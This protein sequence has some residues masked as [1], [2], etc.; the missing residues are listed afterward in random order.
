M[1]QIQTHV[2]SQSNN[3]DTVMQKSL[4]ILLIIFFGLNHNQAQSLSGNVNSATFNGVENNRLDYAN[5]EIFKNDKLVASLITDRNGYYNVAL[6]TG[7]YVVNIM[8]NGYKTIT[9]NIT[10]RGDEKF[11]ANLEDDPLAKK[12]KEIPVK[13]KP[14]SFGADRRSRSEADRMSKRR[15]KVEAKSIDYVDSPPADEIMLDD[16]EEYSEYEVAEYAPEGLYGEP[17]PRDKLRQK[18]YL[19]GITASEI[20]DFSKWKLWE[21]LMEGELN[22]FQEA[23]KYSPQERYTVQLMSDSKIPLVDAV[24]KLLDKEKNVLWQTKTDNTGKAELWNT[25]NFGQEVSGVDEITINYRG[26]T[27]TIHRPKK[28]EKGINTVEIEATC[29]AYN[30]VDI[31]FVVDATGSMQDEIDFL[32]LEINDVVYQ[33]KQMNNQLTM[34]FGSVFYRD[35]G[36][37]YLTQKQDFTKVLSES[38]SFIKSQIADGGGDMPEAVDEGLQVA[39]EEM[40]WSEEARTRILF[41][42]LDA[43]PHNNSEVQQRIKKLAT[44]AA[45]KGIRIVPITASGL[46]KTAEYLMRSLALTTNGTY[47]FITD[48]SGIGNSHLKPSTDHYEVKTLN[49]LLTTLIKNYI[50]V[51]GCQ[52]LIPEI[53]IDYPDSL[54]AQEIPLD[55]LANDSLD[56]EIPPLETISWNFYPNPTYGTL[57]IEVSS[58]VEMLYLTDMTGK[59]L[60]QIPMNGS[61]KTQISLDGLP[62]GIYFLRY[63]VGKQWLTGKVMLMR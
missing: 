48:D 33:A 30:A 40:S 23:W 47:V 58:A 53:E 14:P 63:P 26:I 62:M 34:R 29:E 45:K 12:D 22:R 46:N 36:D 51:P 60:R 44:K 56:T 39:I 2:Y 17:L 3:K 55:S 1:N 18:P 9:K 10:I 6:D 43:P 32:K 20:N 15:V 52:E 54:V 35:H 57:N 38:S 31:A 27:K 8:Y 59:V 28:F 37:A 49:D 19:K 11:E 50:Y 16:V 21:D 7:N 42:I 24:V 41:L 5:V 4:F 61:T 13:M 25:I